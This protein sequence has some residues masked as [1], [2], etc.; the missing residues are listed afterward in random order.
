M[1]AQH[2][3]VAT[4]APA[5]PTMQAEKQKEPLKLKKDLETQSMPNT[6]TEVNA[7][8]KK[9]AEDTLTA[10]K[11]L[12]EEKAAAER[13]RVQAKAAT[14]RKNAEEKARK[15][16]KPATTTEAN[17]KL[18]EE[19]VRVPTA[20]DGTHNVESE[21]EPKIKEGPPSKSSKLEATR[22]SSSSAA[23]S[24]MKPNG[25]TPTMLSSPRG[26]TRPEFSLQTFVPACPPALCFLISLSSLA[27]DTF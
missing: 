1:Q 16:A 25:R 14:E 4:E 8:A 5:S 18:K 9:L 10:K 19:P 23:D 15:A 13:Q 12:T 11:K 27:D 17:L 7:A 26:S 24:P 20:V 6:T 21:C 22:L 2:N 3:R